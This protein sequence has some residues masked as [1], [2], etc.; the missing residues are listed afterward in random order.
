MKLDRLKLSI[1]EVPFKKSLSFVPLINKLKEHKTLNGSLDIQG[2]AILKLVE[3]KPELAKVDFNIKDI[4]KY[5]DEIHVLM[6]YFF[7]PVQYREEIGVVA[8]PFDDQNFYFT[9][10]YLE[11]YG[12]ENLTVEMVEQKEQDKC[13]K[14]F[15]MLFYAYS[16]ILKRFYNFELGLGYLFM[17]KVTDKLNDL[18][19]YYKLEFDK[20]CIDISYTGKLPQVS[21]EDLH[22]MI[23]DPMNMDFWL[24]TLPLDKF[25]FSGFLPFRYVDV[26]QIEVISSLKS[27]LLEKSSI[28]NRNNFNQLEQ[29][30]RSLLELPN[31]KLGII[32]LG[33]NQGNVENPSD[34]WHGFLD[35]DRFRCEDYRGTMYE[36]AGMQGMP[37]LV[38]DLSKKENPNHVEKAL[39][40]EGIR[41]IAI[42]PLYNDDELVGVMELG[43]NKAYDITFSKLRI[44]K[45]IIPVFS[46]AI[47]RTSEELQNRIEAIIKEECTAI[48]PSV[49]WR[50]SQAA[51]NLLLKKER[52]ETSQMEEIVF[53][54]VFPLY[55]AID[56]RHSSVIRN[57]TIQDDLMEQL[58]LV[59][60]VVAKVNEIKAMPIYDQLIYKIDYFKDGIQKGLSSGD[61]MNVL[62]FIRH[63]VEP[64]FPHF[65]ENG[66]E[67]TQTIA[68]YK[69][70]IN[71]ELNLVYK[72]RKDFEDSL[73]IINDC[74]TSY[75]E[76]E[77]E[78]AQSMFPHYFEKYRTDGVE[79]NIYIG[80][81]IANNLSFDRIYLKN[82]R[83]WQ[84]IVSAELARKTD[85]L[86]KSL[87]IPMDTTGL[88]LVHSQPLAIRFRQD[89]KKFDVDGA[90]NIRY[91][92]VKK[93]IDKAKIKGT[94]ER[95]TQPGMLAIIFSQEKEMAEYQRYLEYLI[96]AGY[97]EDQIEYHTL[98]DLQGVY[99]L[100]AI[101]VKVKNGKEEKDVLK[102]AEE[103]KIEN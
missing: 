93:R 63:E 69:S 53:P 8:T 4:E 92:I 17:Y 95:L 1:E 7:T 23:N 66:D 54:N 77:E 48:H 52:N 40:D 96:A 31:L 27:Q 87:P 60:N 18:V 101:R 55:G 19:K 3:E 91:E 29:N 11:L 22:K 35:A 25:K 83:L 39:L 33:M 86:K 16:M 51:S 49:E 46:I 14:T 99:G 73:G 34:F 61:E 58:D 28:I 20:S 67:V 32:A 94:D 78:K 82:L 62:N 89:E 24:E 30:V 50:F 56:V 74:V 65:E 13:F 2:E 97:F 88:I 71:P 43:S 75:L 12:N 41:N 70:N 64:L 59:R 5:K 68:N 85:H 9:P 21:E 79:H 45:D 38:N 57:Q 98:E 103:L 47:Q 102:L 44:I 37:V 81:S 26:S 76:Q 6:S 84:L 80:E 15:S 90:Y 36:E 72:R 100:R 10:K 42:V